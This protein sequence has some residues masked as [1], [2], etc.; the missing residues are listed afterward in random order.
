[1]DRPTDETTADG[2]DRPLGLQRERT[3]LA[4]NRTLLALVVATALVV[5]TIGPPY[6]RWLHAPAAVLGVVT[7]W[8][9]LAADVRYRR[10]VARG[11][12]GAPAHL[13]LLWLSA[14][15]SGLGGVVA[16]VVG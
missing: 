7:L 14:V 9:W 15:A 16:V 11:Q 6:L 12:G 5:R 1:M 3:L 13:R 4:W 2:D 8:L 10:T